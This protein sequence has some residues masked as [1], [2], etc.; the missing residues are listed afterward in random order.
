MSKK[1]VS[2]IKRTLTKGDLVL[3]SFLVFCT[4]LSFTI[5]FGG[6][7]SG[8]TVQ[9]IVDEHIVKELPLG[10]AVE[11]LVMQGVKGPFSVE[12]KDGRVRMKDSTC[13]NKFCVKMG[14]IRHEGQVVCC[15]P[16]RII[17]KIKGKG[18]TYD[19]LAR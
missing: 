19:A 4:I 7:G 9:I 17:L 2:Y 13:P 11:E 5:W 10:D 1:V 16:N 3:I 15:I 8:R 12:I 18:E 6:G 14:W